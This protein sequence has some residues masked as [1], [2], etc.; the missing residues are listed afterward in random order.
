MTLIFERR[1]ERT[2][3]RLVADAKAG[4]NFEAWTFDD[5]QSRQQAE[6]ELEEKG[7]KAR[8]RSAYKPLVNAF[9]EDIDLQGVDT[10]EIQYPVHPNAPDN[11][12]RLEAYPLAAM[13]G[14][15][16]IAFVA[17]TDSEFH[18]DVLLKSDAGQERQLKVLVPN[19]VHIDAAG[20]TSVSPTGWLAH[21]GNV[22]GERL[23]TDYE[24]L[25]EETIAVITHFD[26]GVSEP[27]F[28]E[29]N[30]RVTLPATDEALPVGDE[31]M[32]LREALHEDFYFS[33]LEFFQKK[34][35]R[36][37]GDRGLKPGQIVPQILP[38][39]GE[40]SVKVETQPLTSSYWDG[41][42]QRIETATE[43]L[44]VQQIEAV[45]TEI[46]GEA[47]EAVTR[48]GRAVRARYIKGRDAAVM[49]SGGQHANETTGGAG[50][51]RAAQQ[52][53][54]IEGAHF[55]ISPLENPDGYALHQR[56]RKDSPR[57]MYHA[58]RYTALGDDLEYRT[59]ENAGPYLYEKKIRFKAERLS[60]AQL[61]VNLHGYPAHEWTRPLSGY[62][63]RN[64]AMW[65][66]P[67]GFFLIARYHAGW[68]AQAE[69]L[70]DKV[71]KH[72]GSIP[73]LL[74]Y[75]NSQIALY[76]THA[77]ET[78]FRIINGFPCLANIDDRHTVPMTLITEYPDET[79]YGEAFIAGHTAQMETVLS[80]YSAWQ[81]IMASS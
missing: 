52:L 28:E 56:L 74:D 55:T 38:S 19:H 7:V 32:S 75:N 50:A 35:G 1:F 72:L 77:G 42:E 25:F 17:R 11:R 63:P 53:A 71:T 29:L 60:G 49:I 12:F 30:I 36:P 68:A 81:E 21:E 79:I 73:G 62:V 33:L 24:E 54:G 22:T 15:R 57:H 65:T 8:I 27:Y 23:L 59:E 46:G 41:V 37:L 80:A 16:K 10:I 58:A 18:Y 2:L 20:E 3:L 78:S 67:K 69:R 76:E 66:L 5:R 51:L 39:S 4:R 14:N 9:I 40:V 26:W 61:H 13:V 70:L 45:L 47:F 48:S 64:F 31:V 34:S 6:R 43:P 44:A